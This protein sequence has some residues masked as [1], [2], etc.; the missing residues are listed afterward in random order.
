MTWVEGDWETFKMTAMAS[1]LCEL[2]S[3]LRGRKKMVCWLLSTVLPCLT[4][5]VDLPS[6]PKCF[7]AGKPEIIQS[8]SGFPLSGVS[9]Y[10]GKFCMYSIPACPSQWHVEAKGLNYWT[11]AGVATPRLYRERITFY[12][13]QNLL[14]WIYLEATY[15]TETRGNRTSLGSYIDFAERYL[16]HVLVRNTGK[17]D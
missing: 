6:F 1:L 2:C 8:F 11:E 5:L 12:F 10:S 14:C 4:L 3:L 15:N 9:S 17:W 7:W 16:C 13:C